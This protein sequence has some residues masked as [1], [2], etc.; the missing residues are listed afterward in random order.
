MRLIRF[1]ALL[2]V[3]VVALFTAQSNAAQLPPTYFCMCYCAGGTIV[4]VEDTSP[5]CNVCATACQGVGNNEM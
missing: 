2:A 3:M 4:C 1:S 5:A